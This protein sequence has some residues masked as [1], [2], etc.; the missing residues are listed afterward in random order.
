[1]KAK[2]VSAIFSCIPVAV[3]FLAGCN[4]WGVVRDNP[5]DPEALTA[6]VSLG[7]QLGTL[8][9]QTGGSAT[10]NAT[11][12]NISRGRT[13]TIRWFSDASGRS[14]ISAPAGIAPSV[15]EVSGSNNVTV[16]MTTD[17]TVPAGAYYFKLTEVECASAAT[18]LSVLPLSLGKSW[19]T[20]LSY[21]TFESLAYGGGNFVAVGGGS[22]NNV[23]VYSTD[24][25][26]TWNEATLPASLYWN[27]VA[28]DGS[29]NFIAVASNSSTGACSSDGG[30]SWTAIT[31]PQ[32]S[33]CIAYG[34]GKFVALGGRAVYSSDNGKTWTSAAYISGSFSA[35]SYGNGVFVAV[36][37]YDSSKVVYSKDGGKTWASASLPETANWESISFGEG[38]FVA[39]ANG[40]VDSTQNTNNSCSLSAYSTDG[41]TWTHVSLPIAGYWNAVEYGDESFIALGGGYVARSTDGGRN[42]TQAGY[43]S[44]NGALAYGNGRFVALQSNS[45]VYSTDSGSSWANATIDLLNTCT[46]SSVACDEG[47][48]FVAVSS[49]G[50]KAAH[51]NGGETWETSTLPAKANWSSIAYGNGTFVAVETGVYSDSS[52]GYSSSNIAAYSHDAGRTW[53]GATLPASVWWHSVTFGRGVFV[54]VGSSGNAAY[55]TDGVSWTS[56]TIPLDSAWKSVAYGNEAFVATSDSNY[57]AYSLDDGQNWT[58]VP[59]PDNTSSSN[60]ANTSAR[61]LAYGNGIFTAMPYSSEYTAAYSAD[62][63]M[64]WTAVSLPS[65][66]DTYYYWTTPSYGEGCFLAVGGY[67]L[68]SLDGINWGLMG[69]SPGISASAVVHGYSGGEGRWVT[70][71]YGIATMP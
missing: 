31:L 22:N 68:F 16:T 32:S 3:L 20:R 33:Q 23:A 60:S 42:W 29:G 1:M 36:C 45:A 50:S 8:V 9:T 51:S 14:E 11:V 59:L 21:V 54:A 67:P 4:P 49:S 34:G 28:S 26:V 71:G 24:Y 37:G 52:G 41:I 56:A 27:D 70:V 12:Q 6:S 61:Y 25:G 43:S 10:F 7:R 38:R 19:T 39:V 66:S 18:A 44:C 5:N 53:T 62:R 13:G 64:T 69:S 46:W 63:G 35:M 55:S 57:A 15:S 47:G 58:L 48:N 2:A 30:L 17:A 65:S 40:Q